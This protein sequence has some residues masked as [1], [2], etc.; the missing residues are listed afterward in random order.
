MR[1]HDRCKAIANHDCEE[2][3]CTDKGECLPPD[4]CR[5]KWSDDSD[6]RPKPNFGGSL[7]PRPK[8]Y[9]GTGGNP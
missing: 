2:S 1:L 4:A 7:P 9:Y 3:G 8:K 5:A 6:R